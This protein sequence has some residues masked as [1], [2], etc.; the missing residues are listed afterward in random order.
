MQPPE[1]DKEIEDEGKITLDLSKMSRNEKLELLRKESPEFLQLVEDFKT[2]LTEVK[3]RLEPLIPF[4][5]SGQLKEG[6]EYI[7]FKHELVLLYCTNISFY[8]VLKC[9]GT[10]S[11]SH[12]VLKKLAYFK[13]FLKELEVVDEK[14]SP[15]IEN[16]LEKIRNNES[17]LEDAAPVLEKDFKEAKPKKKKL[18]IVQQMDEKKASKKVQ[19]QD[20]VTAAKTKVKGRLET[21]DEKEALE[22]Y[23]LMKEG[24]EKAKKN[25]DI[26]SEEETESEDAAVKSDEGEEKQKDEED[27]EEFD[28]KRGITYQIA[29]NKGLMPHRK[30]EYKNPRVKHRMKFRKAKIRRKGQVREPRKEIQRYGGEISGI[31]IGVKHGRKIK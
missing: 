8:M 1:F 7:L 12:P 24:H 20:Q 28:E 27:N 23:K 19:F 18:R 17:I 2:L 13:K 4:V 10:L 3:E 15:Y 25:K 11:R 5:K 21:Q 16:A 26:S 29:K 9:R 22:M 30:K 31:R 6:A 14:F